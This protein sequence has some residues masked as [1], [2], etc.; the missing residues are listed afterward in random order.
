MGLLL[1]HFG[2]ISAATLGSLSS[3]YGFIQQKYLRLF[4]SKLVAAGATAGAGTPQGGY[5][6]GDSSSRADAVPATQRGQSHD[7]RSWKADSASAFT[8]GNPSLF[9]LFHIFV[10]LFPF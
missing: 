3:F 1:Y 9:A 2:I 5:G 6:G 10:T 7:P 4:V 8:S